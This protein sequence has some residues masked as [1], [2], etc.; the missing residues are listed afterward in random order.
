VLGELFIER[1]GPRIA[2]QLADGRLD[3]LAG[4]RA[5]ISPHRLFEFL[6]ELGIVQRLRHG[7]AQSF[8]NLKRSAGRQK[9]RPARVEKCSEEVQQAS[10]CFILREALQ[11]REAGKAGVDLAFGNGDGG[12]NME[13]SLIK[14]LAVSVQEGSYWGQVLYF[15][16]S[17]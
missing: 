1:D 16:V 7:P 11:V 2:R 6:V 4:Q 14:V 17:R 12:V 8:Y 15:D 3:F 10:L 9:I 5:W 13:E